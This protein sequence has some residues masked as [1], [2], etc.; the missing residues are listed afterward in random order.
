[1]VCYKER[2]CAK[3]NKTQPHPF[4]RSK[5]KKSLCDAIGSTAISTRK[6]HTRMS[7][8][9]PSP[10]CH[11]KSEHDNRDETSDVASTHALKGW[12]NIVTVSS[13]NRKDLTTLH[14][15]SY[16]VL[17]GK[18]L[19]RQWFFTHIR[20]VW[21][22]QA[23]TYQETY[24]ARAFKKHQESQWRLWRSHDGELH[25]EI[26][27]VEA[28]SRCLV[29][30]WQRHDSDMLSTLH[31][32]LH[33]IRLAQAQPSLPGSSIFR[34][35]KKCIKNRELVKSWQTHCAKPAKPCL[36]YS[37]GRDDHEGWE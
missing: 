34:T 6:C 25:S 16:C 37:H 17:L 9:L 11:Q 12:N 30:A 23:K 18:I 4:A 31:S 7:Q 13:P 10:Q 8:A 26:Y 15:W 32:T 2:W 27:S 21:H 33:S 35:G 28:S 19:S 29:R 5:W 36:S 22:V 1:M 14:G 24:L 20:Y 3:T